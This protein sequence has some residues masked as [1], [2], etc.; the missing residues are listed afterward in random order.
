[1]LVI[2]L[3]MLRP[4]KQVVRDRS[5]QIRLFRVLPTG[6][7]TGIISGFFGIG[8]GFLIVPAL[9]FSA[10]LSMAEAIGSSLFSF[11]SRDKF[12]AC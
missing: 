3:L 8:G 2:A 12:E 1:M 9:V 11:V 4:K 7:S 6:L 10:G 5:T